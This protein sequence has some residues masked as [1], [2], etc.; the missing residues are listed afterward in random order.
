MFSRQ[1]IFCM[2]Y[3]C[4]QFNPK[5]KTGNDGD[6][7]QIGIYGIYADKHVCSMCLTYNVHDGCGYF[8]RQVRSDCCVIYVGYMYIGYMY[9][10]H[11]NVNQIQRVKHNHCAFRHVLFTTNLF[12]SRGSCIDVCRYVLHIPL[13]PIWIAS[14]RTYIQHICSLS[15]YSIL[16][17]LS[18]SVLSSIANHQKYNGFHKT[19]VQ[20]L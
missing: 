4:Q 5:Q 19:C 15:L 14:I 12:H 16:R 10:D 7:V 13:L 20:C 8:R 18:R 17:Y 3:S 9:V 2:E 1:I 6:D 11:I